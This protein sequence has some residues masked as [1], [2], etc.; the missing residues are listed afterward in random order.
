MGLTGNEGKTIASFI[1]IKRP[2]KEEMQEKFLRKTW[3]Y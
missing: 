3:T 2:D 1:T